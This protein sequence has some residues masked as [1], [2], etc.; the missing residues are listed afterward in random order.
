MDEG[1]VDTEAVL[2]EARQLIGPMLQ[3]RLFV[4]LTDAADPAPDPG[5]E[6]ALL[7]EHLRH[8]V[9]WERRGLLFGAGPFVDAN[10]HPGE[11]S[12]FVLRAGSAQEVE[13]LLAEEPYHKHGMKASTVHEW[14]LNEGR[15]SVSIDF[16]TQRGGL[17]GVPA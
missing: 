2:E 15:V 6:L 1:T 4:V 16:S 17:D 5:A 7:P 9:E 10:G 13:A 11:R 3:R 12:M 8:I 14:S